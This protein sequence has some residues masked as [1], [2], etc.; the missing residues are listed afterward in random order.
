[1]PDENDRNL[2]RRIIN[3]IGLTA[4]EIRKQRELSDKVDQELSE[5]KASSLDPLTEIFYKLCTWTGIGIPSRDGSDNS[6][7]L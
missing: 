2:G 3:S 7:D 5:N 6:P 1:M 4:Q